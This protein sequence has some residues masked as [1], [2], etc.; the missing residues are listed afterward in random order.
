MKLEWKEIPFLEGY[1]ISNTGLI[2]S[3]DRTSLTKKGVERTYSG[4]ILKPSLVSGYPAVV[5][6]KEL[7]YIHRLVATVFLDNPQKKKTINHKNEI[8]TDNRV[9]NLEW[10]TQRENAQYSNKKILSVYDVETDIEFFFASF[11]EAAK[12][13]KCSTGLIS[14]YVKNGEDGGLLLSRYRLSENKV[15]T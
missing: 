6:D 4:R 11:T 15:L 3:N 12:Y 13:F 10:M 5:I 1:S 9:E 8:K 7:Y 14:Y 2:R